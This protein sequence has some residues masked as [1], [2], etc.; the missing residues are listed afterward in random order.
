MQSDAAAA[1]DD[2]YDRWLGWKTA[3]VIL[4]Q[5]INMPLSYIYNVTSCTDNFQISAF[6]RRGLNNRIEDLYDFVKNSPVLF[7]T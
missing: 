2:N 4:R 5:C 1:V 3:A 7:P 6:K